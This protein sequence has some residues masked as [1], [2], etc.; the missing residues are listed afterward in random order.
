MKIFIFLIFLTFN[1]VFTGDIQYNHKSTDNLYFVFTTFR[2]GARTTN[3]PL[4]IFGNQVNHPQTLT[5]YGAFQHYE[6]GLKYRDRY[7]NFVNDF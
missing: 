2:H 6:I 4:D 5:K 3:G 1:L 7:S